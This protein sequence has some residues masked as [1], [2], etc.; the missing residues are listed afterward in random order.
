MNFDEILKLCE[1]QIRREIPEYDKERIIVAF[2]KHCERI[3]KVIDSY[4]KKR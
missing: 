2:N 1:S 4:G 3:Q